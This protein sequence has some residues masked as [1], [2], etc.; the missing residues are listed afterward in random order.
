MVVVRF[1]KANGEI[2]KL[3]SIKIMKSKIV[4]QRRI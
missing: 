2:K 3:K 1:K 4:E